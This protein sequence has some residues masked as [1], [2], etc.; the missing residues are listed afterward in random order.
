RMRRSSAE[1]ESITTIIQGSSAD[2]RK[3]ARVKL[4]ERLR[5]D[6]L[7]SRLLLQIHDELLLEGPPEEIDSLRLAVTDSME[8]AIELP[9]RLKVDIGV[10]DNWLETK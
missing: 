2:V 5:R 3:T 9:V 8:N 6:R 7:Q 4:A 1:L 10:G